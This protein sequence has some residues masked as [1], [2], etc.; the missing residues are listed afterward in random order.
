ML[1]LLQAKK[2]RRG[3]QL[4]LVLGNKAYKEKALSYN[5]VDVGE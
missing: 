4:L 5:R 3:S 1:S 2:D